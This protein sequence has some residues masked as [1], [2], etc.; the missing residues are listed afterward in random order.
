VRKIVP[1]TGVAED[2]GI[3][4]QL[5]AFDDLLSGLKDAPAL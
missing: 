3:V 5:Q 1:G 4:E 2:P